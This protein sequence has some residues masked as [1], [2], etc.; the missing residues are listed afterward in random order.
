MDLS[1]QVCSIENARILKNIG[2]S[3]NSAVLYVDGKLAIPDGDS[4]KLYIRY[5]D[6]EYHGI[7]FKD[8]VL[9]AYSSAELGE[10]LPPNKPFTHKD[11]NMWCCSYGVDFPRCRAEFALTEADARAQLLMYLIENELITIEEINMRG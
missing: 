1:K 7:L 10:M 6:K 4:P 9:N 5:D 8:E 2:I 11:G 3:I